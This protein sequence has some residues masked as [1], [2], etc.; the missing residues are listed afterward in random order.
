MVDKW[1]RKTLDFITLALHPVFPTAW[2]GTW[3]QDGLGEVSISK[4]A[5][6][7]KGHCNNSHGTKY[8]LLDRDKN[9]F[10]CLIF[11]PRHENILQYK[12]S[13]CG[14][15][16]NLDSVCG[17]F[18]ANFPLHTIVKVS[19]HPIPCPFQ[20]PYFFSY[21][22]ETLEEC[23]EPRSEIHACADK[24][25]FIFSYRQCRH[26]PHQTHDIQLTFQ[27]MATWYDGGRILYGKFTGLGRPDKDRMYRCFKYSFYGT[28]GDMSMSQ[29]AT[30]RGLSTPQVGMNTFSLEHRKEEWPRP[31][32]TFPDWLKLAGGW[33]DVAGRQRIVVEANGEE[34]ALQDLVHPDFLHPGEVTPETRLRARC[35]DIVDTSGPADLQTSNFLTFAT[36][37]SCVS[38]YRCIRLKQRAARVFEMYIGAATEDTYLAC[39]KSFFAESEK[40]VFFPH[41]SQAVTCPLTGVYSYVQ[42]VGDCSGA[43]NI[44]CQLQ[45]EMQ[46]HATCRA[47]QQSEEI[48]QCLQTWTEEGRLHVITARPGN[49]F[50]PADCL[51]FEDTVKGY[52]LT[53][54][55]TC[56]GGGIMI[57]NQP[58]DFIVTTPKKIC[59]KP[60]SYQPTPGSDIGNERTH[61]DD[62]TSTPRS[63]LQP[64]G[65]SPPEVPKV[66]VINNSNTRTCP[67]CFIL[68]CAVLAFA[69]HQR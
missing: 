7:H 14:K 58:I 33:R 30:C 10:V 27:C 61:R 44:G 35:L 32:C 64:A 47:R 5:V 59:E 67:S 8:L 40:H 65:D 41:V 16:D 69:L 1:N 23:D 26:L 29:D 6:S 38:S 21:T 34:L 37:D 43:L 36:N 57:M 17:G 18:T 50:A 22:N 19:G 42:K 9:C 56:G 62:V 31:S 63:G 24:S 60:S 25:R 15:D 45:T 48:L 12:E 2:H 20:G 3:F 51:V 28:R 39:E 54:E 55:V 52:T 46:L 68:L 66:R 49:A 4:H 13:Y 53:G 11:T